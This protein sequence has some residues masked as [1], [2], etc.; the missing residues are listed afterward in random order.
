MRGYWIFS[1]GTGKYP[2]P[3]DW[4]A[5]WRH[6]TSEMWFPPN[7]KPSGVREGDRAI[8][9]GSLGRGFLAVVEVI[10]EQPE[11]NCTDDREDRCR[12]PYKLRH[13]LV[14]AIRADEHAPSLQDVGWENP[15]RLRRQPHVRIDEFTYRRI[16][17]AIVDGAQSAVSV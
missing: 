15:L 10:S 8:I 14:V 7:K 12:W 6:H 2:P 4:L 17:K 13:R 5:A 16:A 9:R 11:D 3:E 1:I